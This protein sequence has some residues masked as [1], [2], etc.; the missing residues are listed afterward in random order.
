MGVTS[1]RKISGRTAA[2]NFKT[3]SVFGFYTSPFRQQAMM[4][5][6]YPS[7]TV[8]PMPALSPTMES[9]SIANWLLKEGDGFEPGVAICEVETDKATVTYEA[10]DD[11]Y[12]AKILVG[13]GELKVGEPMMITVE[14][15][16]SVSA[17]ANYTLADASS[18]QSTT[19]VA[20]TTAV[21]AESEP[22]PDRTPV[23]PE[24]P[25]STA[26][27]SGDRVFASPYARNLARDARLDLTTLPAHGF[28]SGPNNRIIAADVEAAISKG[29]TSSTS[30]SASESST[31]STESNTQVSTSST[32]APSTTGAAGSLIDM[33][34]HSKKV[35][36]H[37]FLSVEVNLSKLMA[38]REQLNNDGD[39]EVSVQDFLVKAAAKAMTK[40][41]VVNSHWMDSFVRRYDQVDINVLVGS[42][43]TIRAPVLK[44]AD[45]K[46]LA[47]IAEELSTMTSSENGE[48]LAMGTFSIHN[49][50]VF[51]VKSAAPIVLTP[52][53]CALA[54]GTITDTV[55][56]N[57]RAA[58]EGQEKWA[59]A[60]VMVTTLSCD[61]R[62]VD[63]AVGAEWLQ[64]F[65]EYAQNPI[66]LLL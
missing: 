3:A 21:P 4:F 60:P 30:S 25:A 42:G 52:Q 23:K 16:S 38:L 48:E 45:S 24:A 66:T 55:I 22:Q 15:E 32:T 18:G 34:A 62:V 65:K 28:A 8:V 57:P 47:A 39:H 1:G 40:V 51:G 35:V 12:I 9:G 36:P 10:T 5:S 19:S 50:G 20:E 43:S 29:I 54:L 33:F 64:A 27:P 7:H 58:E 31:L 46:G 56:P 13:S 49:L 37:Y 11:G 63:G 44:G 14:D 26:A 61:H 17:F 6:S 41:P 53:A 2:H 59:I